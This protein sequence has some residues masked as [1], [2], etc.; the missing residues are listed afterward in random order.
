MTDTSTTHTSAPNIDTVREL[1]QRISNWRRWGEH[2]QLGT[3]NHLRPEHRVAAS[4]L[5]S[6]GEVISL[7]LPLGSQGPQHRDSGRINPVH[8]MTVT[9][10]DFTSPGSAERDV[11]RRY[12]Q[13]ADD[14]LFLPTQSG[15]QWDGLAHV[16]FE[17]QM[18]NGYSAAHVSSNG[19]RRNAITSAADRM[20]ARGVL[21]DLP[22]ALGCDALEPG[23][24]ITGADLDR[25]CG[26]SGV[27]VGPGDVVLVRTGALARARKRGQWADYAGGPAPGLG[28]DSVPWIAEHEIAALATDT[29]DVEVRP[30]Q[31]P[32]VAQPVHILLIV[33]MGLWIGEMFDLEQLA[34]TC[35]R[36]GRYEFLFTAPPLVITGGIGSPINPLAVL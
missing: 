7:S 35:A 18:Y 26:E 9:G 1:G 12:L 36:L 30:A 25:A 2:D 31:T 11:Q 15:T 29:W 16:F 32:D 4:R 20:V 6:S 21:L 27:E 19:A 23:R 10:R 28:L 33:M 34:E 8:L 24:A 14:M 5:V 22:A 3:L 17:Q 13:N